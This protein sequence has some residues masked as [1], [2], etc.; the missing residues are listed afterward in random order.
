MYCA[1]REYLVFLILSVQSYFG[2]NVITFENLVQPI[3]MLI[4]GFKS[5]SFSAIG[6]HYKSYFSHVDRIF[7]EYEIVSW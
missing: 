4:S 5:T 1:S 2:S 3:F 6:E 7:M